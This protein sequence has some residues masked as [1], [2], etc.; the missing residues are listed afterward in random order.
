MVLALR[1]LVPPLGLGVAAPENPA[2][3][4]GFAVLPFMLLWTALIAVVLVRDGMRG[5]A[6]APPPPP[7][8]VRPFSGRCR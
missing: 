2:P 4:T 7:V 6:A 5:A 3:W 1:L 8:A